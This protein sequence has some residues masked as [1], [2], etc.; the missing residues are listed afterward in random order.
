MLTVLCL[1]GGQTAQGSDADTIGATALQQA[2]PSLTGAGVAII[3]AEAPVSTNAFEVNPA[4]VGLSPSIFTYINSGGSIANSATFPNN[5]GAESWHADNVA[6]CLTAIAPGV[7]SIDNYDA[8]YYY[9]QIVASG[10]RPSSINAALHDARI[11]NQSFVFP[12]RARPR[13]R[14]ST[15]FTIIMRKRTTCCS[16]AARAMA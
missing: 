4:S 2:D 7:G 16:S 6:A 5:V 14:R 11:V 3:Q 1:P 15:E 9:S 13:T 10:H 8:N 12:A